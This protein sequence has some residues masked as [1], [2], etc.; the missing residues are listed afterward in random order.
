MKLEQN[1]LW[2]HEFTKQVVVLHSMYQKH[3]LTEWVNKGS[4][5]KS[6]PLLMFPNGEKMAGM[7]LK[8]IDFMYKM[9]WYVNSTFHHASQSL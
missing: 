8:S 7:K 6:P 2:A 1:A 9:Y 5:P 4:L 3:L